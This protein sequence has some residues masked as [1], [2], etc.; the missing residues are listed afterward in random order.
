MLP[1]V[2]V[3][4]NILNVGPC[5]QT[6]QQMN[7]LNNFLKGFVSLSV[8][9]TCGV[10]QIV[11]FKHIFP[12]CVFSPK[13][14]KLKTASSLPLTIIMKSKSAARRSLLHLKEDWCVVTH[15]VTHNV[16]SSEESWSVVQ[17]PAA[18]Q[19]VH[20]PKWRHQTTR[21]ILV[22]GSHGHT[23]VILAEGGAK[24]LRINYFFGF[25]QSTT[26]NGLPHF[27]LLKSK[28]LKLIALGSW[29]F[30]RRFQ[31]GMA[32]LVIFLDQKKCH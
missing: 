25:I 7:K 20:G 31:N 1:L 6:R 26:I 21:T 5:P 8:H 28:S 14:V 29:N 17:W 22:T 19:S 32:W 11:T 24:G 13:I 9:N 4:T 16:R 15:N 18:W 12:I 10:L 2:Y 3:E 23:R 30:L 27:S